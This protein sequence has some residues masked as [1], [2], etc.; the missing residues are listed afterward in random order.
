MSTMGKN[1]LKSCLDNMSKIMLMN[2]DDGNNDYGSI[3]KSTLINRTIIYWKTGMCLYA[4]Q[5]LTGAEDKDTNVEYFHDTQPL[6]SI[7]LCAPHGKKPAPPP[8]KKGG[9]V[10]LHV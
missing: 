2:D 1:M 4:E 3:I 5:K 7:S 10:L 9:G 8:S 6:F